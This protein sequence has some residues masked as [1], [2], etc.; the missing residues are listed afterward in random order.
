MFTQMGHLFNTLD[1]SSYKYAP[2]KVDF[3]IKVVIDSPSHLR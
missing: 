3:N 2:Q 1:V